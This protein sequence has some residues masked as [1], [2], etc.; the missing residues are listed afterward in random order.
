MLDFS[1]LQSPYL[2]AE[3]GINHNGNLQIAK[4]L[5]DAAFACSW[6]CVKFQKR[7]PD[8]CVPEEQKN[9]TK[10]TTPWGKM[11]YLE[12]KRKIEFGKEEYD[13]IDKYCKEKPIS[14]TASVWD[15][16][17]LNFIKQYDIPFIKIA[18]AKVTD[19]E[20]VKEVAQTKIPVILSTGMSSLEEL[21]KAVGILKKYSNNFMIMHTNSSYPAKIEELNLNCIKTLQERYNCEVGY[22]GHE[23]GLEPTVFSV[24]LGAMVIERHITLDRTMWGTDQSS[25]VEPMGMDM[26][27]K[28]IK[29]IKPILGDGIKRVTK[30]ELTIRKKLRGR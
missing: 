16:D 6:D 22:S 17:S 10:D 12:Y 27:R 4:R 14:W 28:R 26:L 15:I 29:D 7:N 8:L 20:L 1:N 13:Y 19:I 25:S 11:S 23:Y 2:I 9:I 21:D 3:L 18:S 5:I 24:V 30:S